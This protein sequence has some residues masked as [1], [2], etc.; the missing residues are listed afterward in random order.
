MTVTEYE[1]NSVCV[2]PSAFFAAA[3]ATGADA[4]TDAAKDINRGRTTN[5]C[6][7]KGEVLREEEE[8]ALEDIYNNVKN[9]TVNVKEEGVVNY[10]SSAN[11]VR[12]GG[13]QTTLS[14]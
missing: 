5:L 3:P 9:D 12:G 10:N 11:L 1:Q 14:L 4:D 13:V 7:A 6:V 2:G 8:T